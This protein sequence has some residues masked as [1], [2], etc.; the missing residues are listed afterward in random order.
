MSRTWHKKRAQNRKGSKQ[1][2]KSCR[3]HGS[4]PWCQANRS[5]KNKRRVPLQYDEVFL[6]E[7]GG[8]EKE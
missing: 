6:E 5:H 1:F 4:C 2:D 7:H 3:N 8:E